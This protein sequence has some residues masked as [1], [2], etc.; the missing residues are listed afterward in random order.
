[1]SAH[2]KVLIIYTGGTIG[3]IRNAETGALETFNFEHLSHHVPEMKSFD[4]IIDS[5][6]FNP[7][8]DSSDMDPS[9]WEELVEIIKKNYENYDGFVIL[10]GTDT[11]AYTAS[12][13]SFMLEGLSKPVILT[14]S[15]LPIDILRT[16][17]KENLLTAIELAAAK[18]ENGKARVAEVCIFF[19]RKLLRGNRVTKADAE[20]FD[21]FCSYNYP[22]LATVGVDIKYNDNFIHK[23]QSEVPF[24]PNA[25]TENGI[26]ALTL[27]PGICQQ[28][29]E[30]VLKTPYI[31]G[32]ILRT[33]GSGNAPR[34]AWLT[35]ALTQASQQGKVIVN[36]TQCQ[37]GSVEMG[38]YETGLQLLKSGVISG[39]DM[40]LEA[41]IT[42]LMILFGRGYTPEEVRKR[43]NE[44]IAGEISTTCS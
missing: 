44:P 5:Y 21:A 3:M 25:A 1:M 12:A 15:Q 8:I 40:T 41:A 32:I 33:F 2:S 30:D 39:K 10:H 14:G 35:E 7:P 23:P 36:I 20:Q 19:E 17:G 9:L 24:T 13:L 29:L 4:F 16:D 6:Q 27:F 26:I 42:K 37:G 28:L 18:D 11:M 31:K 34:H 43:M 22:P 38:R